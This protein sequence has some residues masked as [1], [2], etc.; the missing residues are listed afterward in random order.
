MEYVIL[1]LHKLSTTKTI[2]PSWKIK[3]SVIQI[4]EKQKRFHE[5]PA[6][7]F[8]CLVDLSDDFGFGGHFF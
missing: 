1:C 2:S 8:V 6:F 4:S 3:V 5:N 7:N